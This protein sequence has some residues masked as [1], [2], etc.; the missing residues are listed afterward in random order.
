MARGDRLWAD[1]SYTQALAEYRLSYQRN[2][3]SDELLARVAH[4]YAVTGDFAHTQQYY[5]ELVKRAPSYTDEAVFDYL[6]LARKAQARSDRYGLAGAVEA[7]VSLR[8]GLPVN[9]LAAGLARYYATTG[10]AAKSLEYYERALSAASSDSVASLLFELATVHESHGNCGDAITMFNAFRAKT[11]DAE[12]ADQARWHIGS[13]SWDLARK[14]E[15]A[16]DTAGA[17]RAIQTVVDLGVPQNI[18]DQVWFE[19]GEL[20][21]GQGRRDE[22]LESYQRSLDASRSGA[23][24][25]AERARHRMDEIRFGRAPNQTTIDRVQHPDPI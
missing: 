5:T 22:A 1:S 14:A 7:A 20:L 19:R 15:Q 10:D 23:G 6:T 24:Q 21:L 2:K 12:K 17:L 3:G 13:C 8:P 9:D 25:L 18:M 11:N 4:A 16:A